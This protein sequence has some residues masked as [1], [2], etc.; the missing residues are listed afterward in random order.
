[1]IDKISGPYGAFVLRAAL[2]VM[3][4]AHALLKPLVF[5][6]A[7]FGQFLASQGLPAAMAWPVFLMEL[8]GGIAILSGFYGRHV[9]LLL[10]PVMAVAMLVH[11]PNGWTHTSAGGGWEYPAFLI[12]ASL[13]HWLIGDGALAL[14]PSGLLPWSGARR[15]PA[16]ALG[17][18]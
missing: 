10:T 11:V 17:R 2:G 6:M 13:A 9:S 16:P 12:A 18:A 1:M 4:I 3:W 15:S 14:K 7:G 5:T 8:A